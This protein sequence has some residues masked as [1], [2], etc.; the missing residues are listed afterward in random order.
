MCT[1]VLR[2]CQTKQNIVGVSFTMRV[3]GGGGG[4]SIYKQTER[5]QFHLS[6]DKRQNFKYISYSCAEVLEMK[7][8]SILNIL[9]LLTF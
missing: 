7:K 3:G 4:A 1:S 6:N 5:Y 9:A 2:I 8:T